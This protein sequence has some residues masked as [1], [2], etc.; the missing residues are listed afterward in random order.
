[1][2]REAKGASTHLGAIGFCEGHYGY[3][4]LGVSVSYGD[5]VTARVHYTTGPESRRRFE[6]FADLVFELLLKR[7][8][9]KHA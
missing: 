6:A 4:C 3:P 8:A 5:R 9:A 1:M 2:R 7:R